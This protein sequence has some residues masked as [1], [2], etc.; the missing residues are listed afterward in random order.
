MSGL[1]RP[2]LLR[3]LSVVCLVIT[4]HI[5]LL[6]GISAPDRAPQVQVPVRPV[7]IART[8]Q[9]PVTTPVKQPP[10]ADTTAT[11][12][13]QSPPAPAPRKQ[14]VPPP[15]Q[16]TQ[17]RPIKSATNKPAPK[18]AVNALPA[19]APPPVLAQTRP[20][21]P[22]QAVTLAQPPL[23]PVVEARFDADYLRNPSPEYP[24]A[25]RRRHQ[26]GTVL[27]EVVVDAKGKASRVDIQTSSGFSSLDESAL[28]A[29]RQWTFVPAHRG[30]TPVASTVR[31]PILFRMQ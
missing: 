14:P 27:L 3:R 23:Q 22:P 17:P 5:A 26:Q 28:R 30:D 15:A 31:V 1:I 7:V 20:A 16:Q 9:A 4:A 21:A 29:V 24:Y 13:A 10:S 8:L 25:A 19:P 12:P 18:P 6:T 11:P 2:H